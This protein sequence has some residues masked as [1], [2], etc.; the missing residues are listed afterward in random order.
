MC[1]GL[2]HMVGSQTFINRIKVGDLYLEDPKY[3]MYGHHMAMVGLG[4]TLRDKNRQFLTPA[5]AALEYSI[6]LANFPPS[7]DSTRRHF[8]ENILPVL[9]ADLSVKRT[10]TTTEDADETEQKGAVDG[11]PTKKS[12]NQ[13]KKA[14]LERTKSQIGTTAPVVATGMSTTDATGSKTTIGLSG[15]KESTRVFLIWL[16]RVV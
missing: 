2:E 8:N 16:K 14:A 13:R 6:A 10:S 5:D 7:T 9:L 11:N 12:R 4:R 3:C 15:Q 1:R